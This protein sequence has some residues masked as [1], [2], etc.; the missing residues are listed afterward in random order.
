MTDKVLCVDDEPNVLAGY[1]RVL[2]NRFAIET[3]CGGGAALAAMDRRGPY[4]VIVS[5]LRMPE[6]DGI[7]FL[8]EARQRA[9]KTVR[10]MLTGYADVQSAISAVNAGHLFRFL[11]KPCSADTLGVALEAGLEQYRLVTAE[12]ELL[13]RTVNGSIKVLADVLAMVNA[14][15]FGRATRLRRLASR[16]GVRLGAEAPWEIEIAAVLSQLGCVTLPEE[17]IEKTSRGQPLSAAEARLLQDH[18]KVAHDLVANIPRLDRVATAIAYQDRRYDGGGVPADGARG[19]A[20]PL[21][22]RILK[23]ALDLDALVMSGTPPMRAVRR[24][25]ERAGWYDP[26]VVDA[27]E[28]ALKSE[29]RFA[30]RVVDVV[31]LA[32]GMLIAE[33][34]HSA[35]GLLLIAK[36]QEVTTSLRLRLRNLA[37]Y[38]TLVGPI[39]VFCEIR[40]I[41]ALGA[42]AVPEAAVANGPR[43]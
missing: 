1:T 37:S 35:S 25:R 2:R 32:P 26:M 17:V 27:L 39:K 31:D 3:E 21:V 30:L 8:A 34:V 14:A 42:T 40:A 41:D 16:I 22:A 24:L 4:A 12:Q 18:P 10:M 15:A 19:D 38:G 7:Q 33:D 43:A 5:D 28:A 29:A 6:M 36:G 20:I 9:P 11:T 13:E 23:V